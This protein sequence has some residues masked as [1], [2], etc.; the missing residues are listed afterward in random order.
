VD[1]SKM[2]RQAVL[3]AE[4]DGEEAPEAIPAELATAVTP[5]TDEVNEAID[6]ITR[7]RGKKG[8][9]VHKEQL[10]A[11]LGASAAVPTPNRDEI[12]A[13]FFERTTPFWMSMARESV[14]GKTTDRRLKREASNFAKHRYAEAKELLEQLRLVEEREKEE[15]KFFRERR[16]QKEKEWEEYEA[17]Q[18]REEADEE[19]EAEATKAHEGEEEETEQTAAE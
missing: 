3:D 18:Q 7:S 16:L 1:F 19:N 5:G 4:D 8:L 9:K 15:A 14:E 2:P 10:L 12:F 6:G 11:Q 17:Q 13:A